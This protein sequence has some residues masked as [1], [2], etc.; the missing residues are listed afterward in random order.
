MSEIFF[1]LK[2]MVVAFFIVVLMQ[3]RV[4]THT[5]E[6]HV[7]H[8]I[9]TA[10]PVLFLREVAEGGLLAIH[11]VWSKITGGIKTGYW[12]RFNS[13]NIPGKRKLVVGLERSET[14]VKEQKAKAEKALE[15]YQMQAEEY[16]EDSP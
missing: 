15:K 6:A 5:V 4:G 7:H 12:G 9:Q 1:T 10:T 3:V 8:Y 16:L 11:D 13:D 14:Y 2:M